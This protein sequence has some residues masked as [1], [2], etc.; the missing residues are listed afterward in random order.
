MKMLEAIRKIQGL[1]PATTEAFKSWQKLVSRK[2]LLIKPALNYLLTADIGEL[3]RK[4]FSQAR[5]HRLTR[6][7]LK[8]I[9]SWPKLLRVSMLATA[10]FS[11]FII[12][13]IHLWQVPMNEL[14]QYANDV[15]LQKS[16]YTQVA[17]EAG[18]LEQRKERISAIDSGFGQM[19]ELIP[20]E[21]EI[22]HVLDQVTTVARDS[23]MQLQFFKP[24]AEIHEEAYVALPI[25]LRLS[26]NFDSVGRF[27][28]SVS[29]LKHLVTIDVILESSQ[30][31]VGKL[32]LDAR[33]RAYRGEPAKNSRQADVLSEKANVVH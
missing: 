11:V 9:E 24:D 12:T 31:A 28:E 27:L 19:L 32:N 2:R 29:R 7:Q 25:N 17:F 13:S 10:F 22:V 16:R 18:L 26:G 5:D 21:L 23:G 30:T 14:N 33:L 3:A 15:A 4:F 6:Y 8:N 1:W 20:A